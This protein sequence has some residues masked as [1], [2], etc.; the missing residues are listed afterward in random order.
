ME[1]RVVP[2]MRQG[3]RAVLLAAALAAGIAAPHGHAEDLAL[4]PATEPV[5]V[6]PE[7]LPPAPAVLNLRLGD[8]GDMTRFVLEL[9]DALE[10]SLFALNDP[11]RIVIDFP[12]LDWSATAGPTGSVGLIDGH[13]HG[14]FAPGVTRLVLDL[15]G[16]AR[17]RDLFYIP[18]TPTIPVRLVLDLEPTDDLT[19][20]AQMALPIGDLRL[21]ASVPAMPVVPRPPARPGAAMAPLVAIDA[22]HGGIDPGAIST[23]G[24]YEK[25]ITL[26]VTLLL[27][28]ALEAEGYRVMLTRGDDVF[29]RLRDR[30]RLAREGGADP[31]LSV[32]AD[33][34]EN[35]QVRGA[36]VY[37]LS[38][39]AS[40]RE[41]AVLAQRENRV[42]ALAGVPLDPEDD[43]M[44]SILI[45]LAQRVTKQDSMRFG[46]LL[47]DSLAP[48]TPLIPNPHRQAG[49]AVLTAPDVP[50]V[51]IELGYLS[52]DTDQ[53]L[54][55]EP[56]HQELL[57]GA[58]AE[59]VD[60]YFAQPIATASP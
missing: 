58:I 31:F 1:W 13:R 48:V 5:V 16:P 54:L 51:L 40:D 32:H 28:E 27:R 52:N 24:H 39:T 29:L 44:A 59:A 45:D 41:A 10:F 4:A 8:H 35:S 30:V 25:D 50:S 56:E 47:I 46:D 34:M 22:G 7:A 12:H 33:S 26:A 42:D 38:E 21:A 11:H 20:A 19:Y 9:T 53:S 23:D 49:F 3:L 37:T 60:A 36:S 17:I 15:T 57:V 14:A 6:D 55:I 18:E 2:M 43:L